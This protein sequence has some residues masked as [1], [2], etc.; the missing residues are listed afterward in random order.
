[1]KK[2]LPILYLFIIN[3]CISQNTYQKYNSTDYSIE[4]DTNWIYKTAQNNFIQFFTKKE[5][6]KDFFQEN[7]NIIIQDLK[8]QNITLDNYSD[9]TI[10]QISDTF[11]KDVILGFRGVKTKR[12]KGKE[13][14][15][16]IPFKIP[17]GKQKILKL[18]QQWY[19]KNE[20]AYLLT[21]TADI[22]SYT[23]YLKIVDNMFNSFELK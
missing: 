9:L 13:V 19:I 3:S 17:N 2:I 11:D 14:I 10:K 22:N 1:M 4:Y 23:K 8:G 16:T 7:F 20:K 12:T 21:Y 18:R 6:E 5:N 15:Y